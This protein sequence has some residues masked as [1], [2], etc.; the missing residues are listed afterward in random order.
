[1]ELHILEHSL[2]VAS[3]E[4]EGI[5]ICT[6]GLIK[7]AF[8]ASK[9]RCVIT[10]STSNVHRWCFVF[11]LCCSKLSVLILLLTLN[12]TGAGGIDGLGQFTQNAPVFTGAPA[13]SCSCIK[14]SFMQFPGL[15]SVCCV[16][17]LYIMRAW[18]RISLAKWGRF[19][20]PQLKKWLISECRLGFRFGSGGSGISE[21]WIMSIYVLTNAYKCVFFLRLSQNMFVPNWAQW[22]SW[23]YRTWCDFSLFKF[24]IYCLDLHFKLN[25]KSYG[26]KV[27]GAEETFESPGT[28]D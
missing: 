3:I 24:D 22:H 10:F 23:V 15:S 13:T 27:C 25:H 19:K 5:Q 9:T 8:L 26:R 16:C 11:C 12:Q 17:V 1:M 14:C 2:K 6:H 18:A 4:K 20:F 7:L 21:G 28:V